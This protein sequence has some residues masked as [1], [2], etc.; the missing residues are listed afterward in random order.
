[1]GAK[2]PALAFV[3]YAYPTLENWLAA[4][5]AVLR[6]DYQGLGT[7]GPHPYLIGKS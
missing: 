4:G 3:T 6:S 2:N 5:Y 7:P 1:M